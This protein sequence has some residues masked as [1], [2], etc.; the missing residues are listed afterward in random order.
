VAAEGAIG[1]AGDLR[2]LSEAVVELDPGHRR[3]IS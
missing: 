1:Q 2:V 3:P